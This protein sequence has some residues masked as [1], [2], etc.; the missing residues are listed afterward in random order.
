MHLP[1]PS[2][3]LVLACLA[4]LLAAGGVSLAAV[5]TTGTAENIVD[6][7]N[8]AQIAKVDPSGHLLVGD[9]AGP[10][11]VDGT[12][13]AR[14]QA[15]SSS[16]RASEDFHNS[17]VFLVGPTASPIQ[18]TSISASLGASSDSADIRLIGWHVDKTA[19]SCATS[20]FDGTFWHI[21]FFTGAAPLVVTFPTPLEYRPPNGTKGCLQLE[22]IGNAGTFNA[23][24]FLG[25]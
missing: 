13:S 22:G 19:T 9:G 2:P 10:L 11:T 12:V 18:I 15:P 20:G 25:G 16:W 17:N 3:A 23:S 5:K 14:P 6:P 1:Q 24:G 8:A 21:P 7:V 4:L